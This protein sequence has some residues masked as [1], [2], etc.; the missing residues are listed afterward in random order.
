MDDEWCALR[1][2]AEAR[3]TSQSKS[4]VLSRSSLGTRVYC[5]V[6]YCPLLR[7][8]VLS[9]LYRVAGVHSLSTVVAFKMECDP[10]SFEADPEGLAIAQVR[11][12]GAV[13]ISQLPRARAE[14]PAHICLHLL[15]GINVH[16]YPQMIKFIGSDPKLKSWEC[17]KECITKLKLCAGRQ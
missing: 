2:P 12:S 16:G 14:Q 4:F 7:E 1:F 17:N 11:H 8:A 15:L 3:K 13:S 10:N 5:R 6:Y 9:P